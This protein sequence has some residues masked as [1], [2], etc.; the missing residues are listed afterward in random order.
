MKALAR[1]LHCP[2]MPMLMMAAMLLGFAPFTP[3]PHLLEKGRMLIHGEL[4]RPMDIFDLFW[5]SWPLVWV[6]LRLAT[7][8]AMCAIPA[9][10]EERR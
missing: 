6:A 10:Q 8:Q 7:P 1:L 5:H 9:H 4:V 3:E 2:P